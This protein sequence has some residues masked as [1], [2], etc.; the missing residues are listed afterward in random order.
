[1]KTCTG[2]L[3]AFA[4]VC[5]APLA[6]LAQGASAAS[7]GNVPGQPFQ[8]LQQQID[9]LQ[10]QIDQLRADLTDLQ[11]EPGPAGPPGPFR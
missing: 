2:I 1:M 10:G 6:V 8:A 11:R 4:L 3:L 9:Q 7:G 5:T